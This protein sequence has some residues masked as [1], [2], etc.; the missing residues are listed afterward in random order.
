LAAKELWIMA[1]HFLQNAVVL[2]G[3]YNFQTDT[4]QVAIELG[5]EPL[6]VTTFSQD[7]RIMKAGLQTVATN[8]SGFWDSDGTGEPDDVLW[9]DIGAT[10]NPVVSIFPLS[11]TDGQRGFS[12]KTT[13]VS[14]NQTGAVG[15]MFTFSADGP[16]AKSRLMNTTVLTN[17]TAATTT[18]TGTAAN[19]GDITA[20]GN[21][22]S[23]LHVTNT[24]ASGTLDV[25]LESDSSSG[26]ASPTTRVTFTQVGTSV[27][28]EYADPVTTS[29]TGDTW[30]RASYTI[31]STGGPSYDFVVGMSILPKL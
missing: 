31:S 8:F 9:P 29:A 19:L 24:N 5:A 21:L 25:I 6:D 28:A 23:V 30:W 20:T 27:T 15:E 10:G 13:R 16:A 17:A 2:Y 1:I 18:G 14:Y 12:Y 22:Y 26:F 4:N 11:A 3:G 7:T